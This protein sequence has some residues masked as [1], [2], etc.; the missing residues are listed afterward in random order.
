MLISPYIQQSET[1]IITPKSYQNNKIINVHLG[2][3]YLLVNYE[4]HVGNQFANELGVI[5]TKRQLKRMMFR[6][7]IV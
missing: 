7:L 5:S 1:K 6:F 2:S 3:V 4:F